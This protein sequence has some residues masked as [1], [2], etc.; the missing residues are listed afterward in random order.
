MKV[1]VVAPHRDDEVLGVGGTIAKL[2]AEQ[3]EVVVGIMTG[4]GSGGPHPLYP[5]RQT[6][7]SLEQEVERAHAV[8]GVRETIRADIPTVLIPEEPRWQVNRIA[9]QMI[10]DTKPDLLFIPF[11]FD[12]HHDHREL[13]RAFSVAWRPSSADGRRI[14]KILAYETVSETH[15]GFPGLEP[16]FSPNVWVDISDFLSRK[17][18][19]LRCFESQMQLYPAARSLQAVEAL[20]RFRGIQV[21]VE[22]AEGFVLVRDVW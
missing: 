22:A 17:L 2:V 9:E 12:M 21:G 14:R 8:L 11:L 10:Q 6:W 4:H 20:A 7:E 19:S 3:H 15:W 18:E 13:A 16:A 5:D 1:L